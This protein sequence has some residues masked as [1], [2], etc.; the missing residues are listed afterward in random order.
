[1]TA[2]FEDELEEHD[3][4]IVA[5]G[6]AIWI[7]SEPTFTD[8]SSFDPEWNGAAL[9][10]SKEARAR[11]L[12]ARMARRRPHALLLRSVG[13]QYAGES[14]PRW[15]YWLWERRDG[16]RIWSGPPDPLFAE[17]RLESA[18]EARARCADAQTAIAEG[19][20]SEGW[21]VAMFETEHDLRIVAR[22]DGT[23]P[24][25]DDERLLL[26]SPHETITPESG[27][28]D[29]LRADR[30]WLLRLR[31]VEIDGGAHAI[32]L[33][34]PDLGDVDGFA[35]ALELVARALEPLALPS[36]ILAGH[37]PPVDA[38][39]ALAS[40]T[41]D[42]AVIEVNGAPASSARRFHED[43]VAWHRVAAEEGL[44]PRRLFYD[45]E[46]GDSGGGGQLTIGGPS[47]DESPFFV[48]PM[49]LP[50]L[51]AFLNRHPSLS[52]LFAVDNVGPW[53]QSPRADEGLRPSFHELRLALSRIARG[54]TSSATTLD[55][56]VLHG[57]LAPFLR[58]AT[59]NAHRAEINVEKLWSPEPTPRG[60][61]G[62]V[63]LRALRMARSPARAAALCALLRSMIAHLASTEIALEL[64]DWGDALHDR[65]ALPTFLLRDL[66]EVL[67]ELRAS[68]V[69]LGAQVVAELRDHDERTIGVAQ[70]EGVAITL[71]RAFEIWPLVG[72]AGSQ[73]QRAARWIDAST[74]R[75]EIVIESAPDALV[76]SIDGA[77]IP[78]HPLD[79]GRA[80]AAVRYRAFVPERGLHPTVPSHC[81]PRL[82][83]WRPGSP[84]AHEITVHDWKP[85]GGAYDGLPEGDDEAMRRR[86]ERFVVS[87]CDPP[88]ELAEIAASGLTLDRR[89]W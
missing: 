48:E 69:G 29:P 65:W 24:A 75:I 41:P 76:V 30:I 46:I 64:I 86:R 88:G 80:I 44:A 85:G 51:I 16:R 53:S 39:I 14:A 83:V 57:T 56:A 9:G 35:T 6:I 10:P 26:P 1:M 42:P 22:L 12:I 11:S 8:A 7:G 50:R 67:G 63:E 15:A 68:G 71:R 28:V 73:E 32:R 52:Y 4:A 72:D 45:G 2:S 25:P 84:R 70:I 19:L 18:I 89:G 13:R 49:L 38:T 31:A 17:S 40:V 60:R 37:P 79:D 81:P 23:T 33:E 21:G 36:L 78:L 62:L 74:R 34:L 20:A 47:P 55:R 3:L 77:R 27:L 61:L 59:G 58:D 5:R 82:I 66:D 43:A 87:E 54:D